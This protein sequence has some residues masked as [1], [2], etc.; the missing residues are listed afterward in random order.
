MYTRDCNVQDRKQQKNSCQKDFPSHSKLTPGLFLM[1]CACQRK[2]VYGFSMM[3]SGESPSMI[4]DIVM[5]RFEENYNPHLI[6]DASCLAKEYGYNRE[7]RRFM[8]LAISTDRFHECNHTSCS[9][10]FKI[11][12]YTSLVN[13]NTEACEQT[14]SALR[15]VAQSTTPQPLKLYVSLHTYEIPGIISIAKRCS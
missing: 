13:I 11:S 8:S 1:T 15:R 14:N 6:Y 12:E 5:T 3:L 7:L 4:F 10:A 2:A 9:A